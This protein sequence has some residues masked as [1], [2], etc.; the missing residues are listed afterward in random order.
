MQLRAV[1]LAEHAGAAATDFRGS[2]SVTAHGRPSSRA[3]P[4]RH[5][6][7]TARASPDPRLAS[8]RRYERGKEERH[9]AELVR[10]LRNVQR[11]LYHC[12]QCSTLMFCSEDGAAA[13]HVDWRRPRSRRVIGRRSSERSSRSRWRRTYAGDEGGQCR[14][15][16]AS[17]WAPA[18][19]ASL[20]LFPGVRLF[21]QPPT[22]C[23]FF[24]P[25]HAAMT[26]RAISLGVRRLARRSLAASFELLPAPRTKIPCGLIRAVAGATGRRRPARG[27]RRSRLRVQL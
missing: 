18:S 4:R 9:G 1:L 5:P 20:L 14:D 23:R 17:A 13:P 6:A 11:D 16:A 3:T 10:A 7:G 8:C 19:L 27:C 26:M 12:V 2:H 15:R 21:G 24:Q 25:S 22:P